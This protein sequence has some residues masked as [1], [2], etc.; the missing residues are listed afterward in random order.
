LG[1]AVLAG[2]V[3]AAVLCDDLAPSGTG[4]PLRHGVSDTS[5]VGED[6]F[7]R[8]PGGHLNNE[9][10]DDHDREQ[11]WNHQQQAANDVRSHVSG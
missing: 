2:A 4:D 8:P 11:R 10:V 3:T 1:A 9:K 6:L 7:D 5:Q